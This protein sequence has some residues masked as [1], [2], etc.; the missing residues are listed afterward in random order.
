MAY[1][2]A[3]ASFR[4][5][6]RQLEGV[7]GKLSGFRDEYKSKM[8]SL[9]GNFKEYLDGLSD[10]Q[11]RFTAAHGRYTQAA[12]EL[13]EAADRGA[14]TADLKS[15]FVDAQRQA[16]DLHTRLNELTLQTAMRLEGALTGFEEAEQWRSERLQEFLQIFAAW[17]DEF[18]RHV[19]DSAMTLQHLQRLI[20]DQVAL[21]ETFQAADFPDVQIGLPDDCFQIVR[22]DPRATQYLEASGMFTAEQKQGKALFI[23]TNSCEG[24]SEFLA[25]QQGEV[26]CAIEE[27]VDLIVALNINGATG[28]VS[29]LVL[30]PFRSP[31]EREW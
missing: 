14:P 8:D 17:C 1:E 19:G 7:I 31:K 24:S 4:F 27:K 21:V 9:L 15:A 6:H 10:G 28:L 22:I 5:A 29:K 30:E 3:S 11:T 26:V 2:G 13:R 23:V 12:R 18:A 20:P 16:V 25:V